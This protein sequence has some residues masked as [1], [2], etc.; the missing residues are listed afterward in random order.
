[1]AA[2][3]R[4]TTPVVLEL[5]ATTRRSWPPTSP[6]TTSWPTSSCR[7][8]S[9][10]AARCAWRSSR[11]TPPR[12][13]WARWWRPWWPGCATEVVGD[14]LAEGVTMGPV[15]QASARDRVERMVAEAEAAAARVHRPATVRPEDAA[16][17]GYLVVAGPR[18]GAASRRGAR[19]P[20]AVRVALVAYGTRR[21]G[22]RRSPPVFGL[23]ASIWTGDVELAAVEGFRLAAGTVFVNCHGMAAM[24]Y[25]DPDGGWKESG[26]GVE[27]G[28][29]GMQALTRPKTVLTQ[30]ADGRRAVT[31]R[32][33][34][35]RL[36]HP[37]AQPA[38]GA[39]HEHVLRRQALAGAGPLGRRGRRRPRPG[40]VPGHPGPL[41]PRAG[42]GAER[43]LRRGG[44]AGLRARRRGGAQPLHRPGRLLLQPAPP[45]RAGDAG[46]G[47]PVVRAGDRA[48]GGR[49]GAGRERLPRG[50]E[51]GG[52]R[53]PGTAPV[54]PGGAGHT[55]A[56]ARRPGRRGRARPPPDGEHG[57]A[58]R[59]GLGDRG[60]ARARAARRRLG[61]AL[62]ALPG[63][64][65]PVRPPDRTRSDDPLAWLAEPWAHP[66]MLQIQQAN[67]E[68]T[69]TGPSRTS[70][71]P[72]ACWRPGRCSRPWPPRRGR[73]CRA[74]A[75]L[76][77]GDPRPGGG[78]RHRPR[79]PPP[80]RRALAGGPG[81]RG[82]GRQ[83]S[84]H[85]AGGRHR[86]GRTAGT[87]G[88]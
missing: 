24:D 56:T 8:P 36:R 5:A 44:A 51:R 54:P 13:S 16:A 35:A 77:R 76:L 59:A 58:A 49:R 82:T 18:G 25:R 2:A 48:G 53:R 34:R 47:A 37:A 68:G 39:R 43:R 86:A 69:T 62:G 60:D 32:G 33:S 42:D 22:G 78:R 40:R 46:G 6:W 19:A 72:R 30:P 80:Q 11:S 55:A 9:S 23:C 75:R 31:G 66:P 85:R 29:E 73:R 74:G 52:R 65:P 70:A 63:P 3:A 67:R 45:P 12:R 87:A 4:R 71:T 17:G 50:A 57:G 15:H 21:R 20:G 84:R 38:A 1:M 88:R 26:F 27:L 28:P 81:R 7:P 83:D 14:G 41:R 61:R 10:P 79:R 64:G